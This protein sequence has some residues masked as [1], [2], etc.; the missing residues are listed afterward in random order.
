MTAAPKKDEETG[1]RE[2]LA[3]EHPDD[4]ATPEAQDDFA[5]SIGDYFVKLVDEERARRGLPALIK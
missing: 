3:V 1:S 5:N 2:L 4:L